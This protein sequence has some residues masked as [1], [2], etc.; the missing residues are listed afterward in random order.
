MDSIPEFRNPR[1]TASGR[2][3]CEIN[4]PDYGWL[5]FTVDP[6]DEGAEFSVPALSQAI[7][8]AGGIAPYAPPDA[9]DL[10]AAERAT[11]RCSRFQARAALHLAGLLDDTEAAVAAAD[12]LVRIAWADA[13]EFRRDSPTIAALAGVLGLDDEDIDALFR[14]AM[15]ITA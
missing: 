15:T 10:L 7:H 1:F 2:I 11:M 4:H 9:A 6:S 12:P 3:D 5:P 8:A 13:Q 14:T